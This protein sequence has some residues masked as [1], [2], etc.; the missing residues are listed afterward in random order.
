[1]LT[2][3]RIILNELITR[4]QYLYGAFSLGEKI[5]DQRNIAA[6]NLIFLIEKEYK[7]H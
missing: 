1:L 7:L 2:E 3:D 5:S 4:A 6:Q